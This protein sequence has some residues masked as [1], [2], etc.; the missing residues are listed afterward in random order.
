MGS[1]YFVQEL[2]KGRHMLTGFGL[3]VKFWIIL[4]RF[5]NRNP[6][7]QKLGSKNGYKN[8][9]YK[10]QFKYD[11]KHFYSSRLRFI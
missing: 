11:L 9:I 10:K 7:V 5:K 3:L 2:P 4:P 6:I 1:L 8:Y